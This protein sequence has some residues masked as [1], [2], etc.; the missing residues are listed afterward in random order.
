[1]DLIKISLL[2]VVRRSYCAWTTTPLGSRLASLRHAGA[3][4]TAKPSPYSVQ[5]AL[6]RHLS[7]SGPLWKDVPESEDKPTEKLDLDVWKSVM[8]SQTLQ[9]ETQEDEEEPGT[10]GEDAELSPLE[11]SRQLVEAWRLAGK[12]VPD[13]MT[14]EQL[15]TLAELTTKSSKKK[16]L[17]YLAI[18]EGYK[19]ARKEK[20][21]KKKED[22]KAES[23][24]EAEGRD[25]ETD[26][27]K[28]KEGES[29][30]RNTFLLKFWDRSLDVLLGWRAAQAM[31]FGQPLVY[32]MSYEQHMS[33]REMENTV[34]QLLQSEGFNRQSSD[35]FHLHF[36][37]L[38]P[39]GAYERELLKRYGADT[40]G[41]LLI[42]ATPQS[43]V[44]V[45]PHESLVYLTA[46][47]PNVLRTFDHNKVYIIGA[48]VDR[49]IQSGVSLANAKRLKLATARL[50]LDEFL[51]WELGAKNLTLDQMIR[52]LLTAKE[53]GSWEKALEF[54]PTRKHDGFHQRRKESKPTPAPPVKANTFTDKDMSGNVDRRFVDKQRRSR[55]SDTSSIPSKPSFGVKSN[56]QVPSRLRTSLKTKME[57]RNN[58]EKSKRKWWEEN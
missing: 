23:E 37:N 57:E 38:R 29:K 51:Y 45:F 14:E 44:D 1:M 19:N 30:L 56:F 50:P 26:E 7:F 58:R 40:W 9:E 55:E 31:R 53:T 18:R 48:L 3:R 54:V 4:V 33:R 52:I 28:D 22:Q 13:Q 35:P 6:S 41:R 36:C 27:E 5:P 32:D 8:R 47:S 10:P 39:N 11:A 21:A 49:S 25:G 24:G 46:D 17:K 42:T 43:Y 2:S 15:E 20:K 34:S 16:F 12:M